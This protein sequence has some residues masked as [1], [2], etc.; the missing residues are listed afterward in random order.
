MGRE[1]PPNGRDQAPRLS[2]FPHGPSSKG[3]SLSE[4]SSDISNTRSAVQSILEQFD[5]ADTA[6]QKIKVMRQMERV[7]FDEMRNFVRTYDRSSFA[8]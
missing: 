2:L 1:H 7:A 3:F 4:K 8:M 5:E 6:S